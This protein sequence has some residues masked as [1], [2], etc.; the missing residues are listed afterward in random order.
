MASQYYLGIDI[1]T[2]R[3]N[4]AVIDDTGQ[5]LG[6]DF[7]GYPVT[8]GRDGAAEQ[9]PLRWTRAA[10]AAVPGACRRAGISPDEISAVCVAGQEHALV[11][12][13]PDDRPLRPAILWPDRRAAAACPAIAEIIAPTEIAEITGLNLSPLHM[14]PKLIWL[15]Q[16]EPEIFGQIK[17]ISSPASYLLHHITGEW[18]QDKPGASCSMLLDVKTGEWSRRMIEA[19]GIDPAILPPLAQPSAV[20]GKTG[21]EFARLTGLP[22][23][24]PA[25]AGICRDQASAIGAGAIAPGLVCD[26]IS[27]VEPV[28][29][30]VAEY[31]SDQSRLLETRIASAPSTWLLQN[32]GFLSG[33]NFKWL[34]DNFGKLEKIE[35]EDT[36][37]TVYD[38]L[39]E[40]AAKAPAGSGGVIFFPFM[41]GAMTPEWNPDARGMYAGLDLSHGR[42]HIIRATLEGSAY[43]LRDIV[44]RARAC[45]IP[46]DNIRIVGGATRSRLMEQIR[47]D[48]TGVPVSHT[49]VPETAP[50][51]AA[52]IASV[53]AGRFSSIAEAAAS[54]V[55]IAHTYEPDPACK[56][57]YDDMYSKYRLIYDRLKNDF[58]ALWG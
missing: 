43:A 3:L 26:I 40:Q 18:A 34:A 24:I 57:L 30:P 56:S 23:G 11:A 16:N 22:N 28:L 27:T 29:I 58:S 48:A 53:A 21:G 10:A 9:D 2:E 5:L 45:A 55:R 14:L 52:L 41:T 51:G 8:T 1:D 47:A 49:S 50:Y 7:R 12:T 44:E 6:E 19:A 15:K 37:R 25:A 20:A 42:N 13:G 54:C 17:K 35:T 46:V 39:T 36:L 33:G 31:Y 32:P 38:L 4:A